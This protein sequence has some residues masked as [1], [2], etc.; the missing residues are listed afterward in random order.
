MEDERLARAA[1]TAYAGLLHRVVS[2]VPFAVRRRADCDLHHLR[3]TT[4]ANRLDPALED[5]ERDKPPCSSSSV[6]CRSLRWRDIDFVNRLLH[7]RRSVW[8]GQEDTPKSG[9]PAACR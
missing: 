2:A 9:R 8:R 4:V 3:L 1:M 7:V 5:A 6:T